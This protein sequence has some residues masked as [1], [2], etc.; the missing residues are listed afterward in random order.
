MKKNISINISGIIF[1]IEED[2]YDKLK[3]YLESINRYFSSFEDSHEIIADIEGRIA[4]IFLSKLN[5]GKQVIDNE[6][7]EILISTM[8]SVRDFQAAEEDPDTP[9]KPLESME[10]ESEENIFSQ[11]LYRDANRKLLGGVLSGTA[12]YF[13][14]DP[15]WTRLI[16]LLLFFG[17]SI[18]PSIAVFLFAAYV[19]LWVVVPESDN[20]IEEK[21]IKKMYRDPDRK[22]LGGVASG[23]ASYFGIDVVVVRLLF[24]VSIFFVGSGLILYIILWIILP[25]AKSI[26]DKMEMKG[27]PVTLSNIESNIRKSLNVK[28]DGENLIIKILL[29]PFRLIAA[30]FEVLSKALGPILTFIIES[31]RVIFGVLITII[32]MAGILVVLVVLGALIGFFAWGN[33][34]TLF[35]L[36][37]E[38]IKNDVTLLSGIA[39]ALAYIIPFL[40]LAILGFIVLMKKQVLNPKA[41]WAILAVWLTSVI[42]LSF[43]VPPM[44]R[45][46]QK[47]GQF[48]TAHEYNLQDK[49]AVLHFNDIGDDEFNLVSLYIKS[50]DG[51]EIKLE[52]EFLAVGSSRVEAAE[53]AQMVRYGVDVQD[54]VF[55][56]NSILEFKE[57]AKFR[58]QHLNLTLYIPEGQKFIMDENMKYLINNFMYRSGFSNS[59]IAENIWQFH[60]DDLHCM[61]CPEQ[62]TSS[63]GL[64][65]DQ[66]EYDI[67]DF[68][69]I[70]IKS[71]L[72]VHITQGHGFKVLLD[73]EKRDINDVVV[74]KTGDVLTIKYVG[75]KSKNNK[76]KSNVKIFIT[77]P[78][79]EEVELGSASDVRISGFEEPKMEVDLDGAAKL[80]MDA[81]V[82]T[83]E[84]EME[85]ASQC[86]LSGEGDMLKAKVSGASILK[87]SNFHAAEIELETQNASSASVY[88]NRQLSIEAHGASNV[89]YAGSG[90]VEIEKHGGSSVEKE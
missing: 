36:P 35:P 34:D 13:H 8:G 18:L 7:I 87:A 30:L 20:L 67:E 84:I 51:S 29:F 89:T 65:E 85:G 75:S 68:S 5:E 10:D 66:R 49:T 27:Q 43:T 17:V 48:V 55:S 38:L 40:Y 77:M 45:D 15:L 42:F 3:A 82:Q 76:N 12:Y 39:L 37:L 73:G 9:K 74:D 46:F 53:N 14:I 72:T 60:D 2:G 90:N 88:A 81:V 33:I 44:I 80:N 64:S 47:N 58:N 26:T 1:H 71:A 6:D 69:E 86:S 21:K 11:K 62:E 28:D 23:V 54:S 22:V 79:L 61:T 59:Q 78:H 83:L 4:E 31:M 25:E 63:E 32:G 52:Q 24:F 19:V 56:F 41:G 16:Y 70:E 57:N 50:H